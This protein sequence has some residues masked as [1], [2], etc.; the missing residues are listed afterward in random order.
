VEASADRA[1]ILARQ[2]ATLI[3]TVK[4]I[5]TPP[6]QETRFGFSTPSNE[7]GSSS[8]SAPPQKIGYEVLIDSNR[9]CW[10]IGKE[11]GTFEMPAPLK[12]KTLQFQ[13]VPAQSGFLQLPSLQLYRLGNSKQEDR[14]LLTDAQVYN[15]SRGQVV[16]VHSEDANTR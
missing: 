12:K 5:T 9:M 10:G 14:L 6:P 1:S 4:N 15:T 8:S 2:P 3:C 16:T 13:V 7:D 11:K